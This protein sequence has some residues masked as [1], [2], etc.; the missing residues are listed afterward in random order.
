VASGVG[1]CGVVWGGVGW[2]GVVWGG[3]GWCGV[4]SGEVPG[5]GGVWRW[6]AWDRA[7]F[8]WPGAAEQSVFHQLPAAVGAGRP[9]H[10]RIGLA[11]PRRPAAAAHAG[12][13]PLLPPLPTCPALRRP[14][15]PRTAPHCPQ[16]TPPPPRH[17]SIDTEVLA[18]VVSNE[19]ALARVLSRTPMGRVGRPEEVGAAGDGLQQGGLLPAPEVPGQRAVHRRAFFG[20]LRVA[21]PPGRHACARAPLCGSIAARSARLVGA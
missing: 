11:G 6:L 17:D 9:H 13:R 1:W 21:P 16:P 19:E 5:W 12:P 14:P 3:V 2:C 10:S 20:L 15:M 8:A 7:G 4:G 18:A